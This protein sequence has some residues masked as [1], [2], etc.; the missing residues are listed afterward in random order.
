MEMKAAMKDARRKQKNNAC[1]V[2]KQA[3]GK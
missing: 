2:T 1:S 3:H